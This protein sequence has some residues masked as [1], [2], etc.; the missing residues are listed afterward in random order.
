MLN[1]DSYI[2]MG[3]GGFFALLGVL[4]FL[5]GRHEERGYY[6]ALSKR[7]D[8]REFLTHL[9]KIIEPGALRIGGLILIVVGLVLVT[10]GGVFLL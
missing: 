7:R 3:L 4:A 5:W 1:L 10:I 8:M 6:D 2:M 9:P